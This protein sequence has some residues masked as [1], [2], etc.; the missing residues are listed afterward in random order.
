[1]KFASVIESGVKGDAKGPGQKLTIDKL[2]LDV[3]VDD[4]RFEN[5]QP[6]KN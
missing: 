1:L 3:A 2:E 4:A 6:A 5:P